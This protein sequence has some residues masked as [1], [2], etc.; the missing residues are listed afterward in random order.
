[1]LS[2]DRLEL[3]LGEL[4]FVGP[5]ILLD[6]AVQEQFGVGIVLELQERQPFLEER[7]R[8]FVFD[9]VSLVPGWR[10]RVAPSE[11][12]ADPELALPAKSPLGCDLM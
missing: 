12:L 11:R 10:F 6:E 1:L 7:G 4:G 2:P 3:A 8:Q 5:R 9:A